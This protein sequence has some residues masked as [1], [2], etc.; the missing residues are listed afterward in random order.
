MV[1]VSVFMRQLSCFSETNLQ[2]LEETYLHLDKK[3]TSQI[4]SNMFLNWI[5]NVKFTKFYGKALTIL[6]LFWK[7]TSFEKTFKLTGQVFIPLKCLGR[8]L[9]YLKTSP[10][11][12]WYRIFFP[13]LWQSR[14]NCGKSCPTII[15][16]CFHEFHDYATYCILFKFPQE[17]EKEKKTKTFL[18][19]LT[20]TSII[21]LN[22]ILSSFLRN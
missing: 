5:Y 16:L 13:F 15:L 19:K 12:S 9:T 3:E 10:R 20:N 18:P 11:I 1:E 2:K 14:I 21:W 8:K 7:R 22:L 4:S 6:R 17:S